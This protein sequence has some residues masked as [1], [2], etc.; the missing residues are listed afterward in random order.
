MSVFIVLG[1]IWAAVLVPPVLR[2]RAER[3]AEFIASFSE[4]MGVLGKGPQA[5]AQAGQA[6]AGQAGAGSKTGRP[7][8]RVSAAKRRRDVLG[9]LVGALAGSLVLG[10]VPAL[11]VAWVVAL[12][13]LNASIG[14]VAV[15]VHQRD[16]ARRRAE[17]AA[18]PGPAA[19][20][21]LVSFAIGASRRAADLP[22]TST[23]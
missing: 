21:R 20:G 17:Q 19:A 16:V 22:L 8:R 14:Y 18:N 13:L 9:G 11:R 7:R 4:Q 2:A 12:F 15:L 3:R 5:A 23:S 10:V 6:G 1:L